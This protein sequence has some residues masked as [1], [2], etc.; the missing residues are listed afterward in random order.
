MIL[1]EINEGPKIPYILDEE[2][3]T[4]TLDNKISIDL[5]DEQTGV[6]KV[7]DISLDNNKELIKGVGKWYVANIVLP[8]IQYELVDTGETDDQ[9]Q[10]VK[11]KHRLPLNLD[12]VELILWALPGEYLNNEKG[13]I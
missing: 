8:S 5:E 13:E 6:E 3:K 7:I 2:T 4:I 1:Q 12:D 11:E 10:P 9:G